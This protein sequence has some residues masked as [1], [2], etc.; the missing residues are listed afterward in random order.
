M[1]LA[2]PDLYSPVLAGH[3]PVYWQERQELVP[4]GRQHGVFYRDHVYL[5]ANP[6][7]LAIFQADPGRY[8]GR[9]EEAMRLSGAVRR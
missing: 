9:V 8:A 3:D 7:S 4:G 2:D 5:F 1:F 6:Q